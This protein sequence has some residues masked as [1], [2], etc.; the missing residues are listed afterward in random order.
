M[1]HDSPERLHSPHLST[2]DS[3][4]LGSSSPVLSRSQEQHSTGSDLTNTSEPSTSEPS[5]SE[6]STSES[7]IDSPS[8]VPSSSPIAMG[9][10]G[11]SSMLRDS[12][13]LNTFENM[14]NITAKICSLQE[15]TQQLL[16]PT[17]LKGHSHSLL[18]SRVF[19]A[20]SSGV[21]D[22]RAVELAQDAIALLK[23]YVDLFGNADEWHTS[24][25]QLTMKLI[26]ASKIINSPP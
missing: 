17:K 18:E 14:S 25:S 6:P 1:M 8:L 12:P 16:V 24:S 7:S 19:S 4:E 26:M 3:S 2:E 15:R 9:S 13:V 22:L 10:L 21:Y 5:T 20:V 23:S 11:Y